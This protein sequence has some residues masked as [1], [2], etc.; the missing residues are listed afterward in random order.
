[1]APMTHE[2]GEFQVSLGLDEVDD[3]EALRHKASRVLGR[4]LS[5]LPDVHVVRRSI[6]ARRGRVRFEL[7]LSLAPQAPIGG[8][9]PRE[10]SGNQRV[11]V[12]GAGP[13]GMF[14][15]YQ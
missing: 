4:P 11:V 9:L 2:R 14:C 7:L 13:A 15:A 10:V 5:E 3:P 8:A 1:C 6:D 12:V